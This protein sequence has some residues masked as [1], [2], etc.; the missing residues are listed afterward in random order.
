MSRGLRVGKIAGYPVLKTKDYTLASITVTPTTERQ[1]ITPPADTSYNEVNIEAV[2]SNIDENIIPENI[3]PDVEILGVTGTCGLDEKY[4]IKKELVN[5]KLVNSNEFMETT[6]IKDIASNALTYKYYRNNNLS[7]VVFCD[8]ETITGE[9]ALNNCFRSSS[10]KS[11]IFP[12]LETITGNSCFATAFYD[13]TLESISFPALT[14]VSGTNCFGSS[15]HNCNSLKM[16]DFSHLTIVSGQQAFSS[17]FTMSYS[18]VGNLTNVDFSSLKT[19]SGKQCMYG[20]FNYCHGLVSFEF[21]SLETID[22]EH[23]AYYMFNSCHGLTT[24]RFPKLK[25][26]LGN[27]A[28]YYMFYGCSS[29][30]DVYFNS[31]TTTSFGSTTKTQFVNLLLTT[32]SRVTHNLH[33]PSN[34]ESTISTLTGYPTFGGTSGYVNLLYDLPATS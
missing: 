21:P 15:F 14:T 30:E 18:N 9:Y 8:L 3:K 11:C 16:A 24:V 13:S 7:N 34:L 27:Q 29:L 28:L 32:G 10:I 1:I 31:L 4:Y 23:A 20:L 26:I 2:S 12:K 6:G 17:V 5:G 22:G 19:I 33:F 25:T